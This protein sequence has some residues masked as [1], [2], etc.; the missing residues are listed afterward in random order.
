MIEKYEQ[1]QIFKENINEMI[2][3]LQNDLNKTMKKIQILQQQQDQHMFRLVEIIQ[4]KKDEI[5]N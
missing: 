5:K 1:K 4:S 3:K 2:D